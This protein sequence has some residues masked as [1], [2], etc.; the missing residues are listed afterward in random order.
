MWWN[1]FARRSERSAGERAQPDLDQLLPAPES[2]GES[3]ERQT[4]SMVNVVRLESLSAKVVIM[5][6][7]KMEVAIRGPRGLAGIVM[8]RHGREFFIHGQKH[9]GSKGVSITAGNIQASGIRAGGSVSLTSGGESGGA[10]VVMDGGADHLAIAIAVPLGTAIKLVNVSGE[11]RIGDVNGELTVNSGVETTISCGR[12]R[13]LTVV[14]SHCRTRLE[15]LEVTPGPIIIRNDGVGNIT[16]R[17]GRVDLF[18]ATAA[19]VGAV[20]YGGFA[21]DATL[22]T[23]GLGGIHVA[24]VKSQCDAVQSGQGQIKID[25]RG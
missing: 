6:G 22:R 7:A 4:F 15:V 18:E 12:T 25:Q 19:N 20:A 5:P 14:V 24:R 3:T 13:S 11:V 8:R 2:E 16:I 23:S 9:D 10:S 21:R 17:G 1:P